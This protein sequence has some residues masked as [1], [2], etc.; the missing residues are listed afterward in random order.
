MAPRIS[1]FID[2]SD[3]ALHLTV[4]DRLDEFILY[5]VDIDSQILEHVSQLPYRYKMIL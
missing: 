1:M 5:S 4:H 2:S 3:V